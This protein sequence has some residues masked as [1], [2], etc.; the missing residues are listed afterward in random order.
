MIYMSK[1]LIKLK[2]KNKEELIEK[3][4]RRNIYRGVSKNGNMWQL[5]IFLK[6]SKAYI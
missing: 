1:F 3:K 2:N 5:I 6:H 4:K